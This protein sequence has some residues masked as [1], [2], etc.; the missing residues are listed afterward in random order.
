MS[1]KNIVFTL[2]IAISATLAVVWVVK[3]LPLPGL[4]AA[5]VDEETV[6]VVAT[7]NKQPQD[8]IGKI[9]TTE[10][11]EEVLNSKDPIVLKFYAP[12]CGACKLA[13][14]MYPEVA[15]EFDGKVKFYAIDVTN[16]DLM[17]A[18]ESK[19]VAKEP[20]Q[21]IPTFVYKHE[22]EGIHEQ[23]RGLMNPDEMK[24]HVKKT[25]KVE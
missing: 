25:L 14:Q 24:Q 2:L 11:L 15:Q 4:G 13:E 7:I 21:A 10:Y 16:Q 17:K 9:T 8:L 6:A 5:S 20:I 18:V 19:G 1:I 22:K 23:T 12:W 3:Y